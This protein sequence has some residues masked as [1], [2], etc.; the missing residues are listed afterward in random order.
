MP[1]GLPMSTL[2][3]LFMLVVILFGFSRFPPRRP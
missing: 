1:H 2:V 3:L